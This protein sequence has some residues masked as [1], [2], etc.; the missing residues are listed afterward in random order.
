MPLIVDNTVATPWLIRPFEHGADIVVHSATKFIGGHGTSIAGVIVDGGTFDFSANDK[1]PMFTEPDPSYHG[2]QYWPALGKGSY[3]IKARVQSAARHRRGH[4]AVQL[5]PAAA[6][7]GDAQ[8]A[9][10]APQRQRRA[11]RG[12]P[13]RPSAGRVG[14]V[15]RP[16][17]TRRGRAGPKTLTGGR[18]YGSVPAFIIEGGIKAGQAFVEALSVAQPRGQHRRRPQPGDPPAVDHPLPAHRG[19]AADHRCR[20]RAWSGSRSASRSI[21]DIIA[22][23]EIGFEAAAAVHRGLT[24]RPAAVELRVE[25]VQNGTVYAAHSLGSAVHG[26]RR[27][28]I[29]SAK[30]TSP[31]PR[32]TFFSSLPEAL[33]GSFSSAQST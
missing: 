13:R 32:S 30:L 23:L 4:L 33:R 17:R 24:P 25:T 15:R 28:Y 8:P 29:V 31:S 27:S 2:L 11:G 21:E 20:A 22:D 16:C 7:P 3:I 14:A 10:G 26:R 18:G 9:H 1:F 12:V 5:V 19:R 6:G